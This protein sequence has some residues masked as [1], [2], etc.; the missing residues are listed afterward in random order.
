MMQLTDK[1]ERAAQFRERLA[2][3]LSAAQMSRSGLARAAGVDR[4]TIAQLLND[5]GPRLPNAH[6]AADIAQSLEVSADWLLGLSERPERPGDLINAAVS[7]TEAARTPSDDQLMDWHR[8]A[9]GYK[10]RHVPA[11][12][13]DMFKTEEVLAWE[14]SRFLGKT[15]EQAIGAMNDRRDWLQQLASDYEIAVPVSEIHAFAAGAG[16]YRDLPPEY[17][18]P[19]LLALAEA[20]R[21]LFPA[22][23]LY[24]FDARRVFSAPVTIFGPL[25]GA[26]YVGQFYL[27]F[28]STERV[29]A[30]TRHF[31]NLIREAEI[32]ARDAESWL[33]A[34]ADKCE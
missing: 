24:F 3:A 16:Y 7:V 21:R 34:M 11:S 27:A 23:R 33:T 17:R 20:S 6:L 22:L 9:R 8:E 15:L 18:R 26:V 29:R 30:L 5:E 25:L 10:I 2:A 32:D 1:R 13:P 12:L 4:S 14:Y 19:Q 31:D 28:R